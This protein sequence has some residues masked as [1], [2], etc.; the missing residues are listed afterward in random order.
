MWCP[1]TRRLL[2]CGPK[3]KIT[4]TSTGRPL[5]FY[6]QLQNLNL[7]AAWSKV[8]VPTLVLHGQYD[9]IMSRDDHELIAEYVNANSPGAAHLVEV[10]E[11]GH[12]LQSYT[13]WAN[14]FAG[15]SSGL[16]QNGAKLDH[17]TG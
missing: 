17:R 14:A 13:N 8:K 3:G 2:I 15:K 10:P 9:W 6:E 1:K 4:M 12:T 16:N 5:A 7:A 11:M